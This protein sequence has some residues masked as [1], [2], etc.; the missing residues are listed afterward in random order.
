MS[1]FFND[2]PELNLENDMSS[3]RLSCLGNIVPIQKLAFLHVQL[4]NL[5][6][7]SN[8]LIKFI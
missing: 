3:D 8:F 5:S 2:I 6:M 7:L 4:S 1:L